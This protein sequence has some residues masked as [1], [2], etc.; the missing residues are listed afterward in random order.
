MAKV[1]LDIAQ[2]L[3]ITCRKGDSFNLALDFGVDM[4]SGGTWSMHVLETDESTENSIIDF[5]LSIGENDDEVANAK[6]KI[7]ADAT[8]MASV[9]SG[10][11]VYDIQFATP[12]TTPVVTTYLYGLFKINEDIT[13]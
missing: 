6:L 9:E 7:S 4:G 10:L 5:T 1:N 13:D 8:A 2:R 12:A 3:D 11:Y